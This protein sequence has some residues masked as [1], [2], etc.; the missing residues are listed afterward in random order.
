MIRNPL[1]HL[2]FILIVVIFS[3][4]NWLNNN[5]TTTVSSNPTF[6]SLTFNKSDS[7]P[8]LSTARFSLVWD[9]TLKDS[10]IM[11][12]DSLPYKTI[13]SKVIPKFSFYSTGGYIVY[14]KPALSQSSDSIILTGTDTLD[15]NRVLKIKNLAADKVKS[16]TYFIKVNVHQVRP[17]L[18]QWN[19]V[20]DNIFTHAVVKQ[21]AVFFK[22]NFLLYASSGTQNYLYTSINA[23]LWENRSSDLKGFPADCN[24]R[25]LIEFN[26]KLYV[27]SSDLKLYSSTDGF[28][29]TIENALISDSNFNFVSILYI[30]NAK[31]WSV[32]KSKTDNSYHF[33]TSTDATSWTVNGLI[34]VNFP[35]RDF[36][37]VSF[38][39]RT[40]LP[41][42]LIAGGYNTNGE[43][44]KNVW[45][46]ENGNYW[47]DFSIDNA[48]HGYIA[49]SSI[50][51]Y[52]NKLFLYGGVDKFSKVIQKP[53]LVSKDDGLSWS[54]PDTINNRLRQMNISSAND[55]TY[56]PYQ[57]RAFQSVITRD[58]NIYLI[59]GV[60]PLQSAT[61]SD[62]WIG[63]LNRL[64]FLRQ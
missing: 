31:L 32:M 5:E 23:K 40:K 55:T 9:V 3:A 26:S 21:K 38:T 1:K 44:L 25:E 27:I 17:E 59:G 37:S 39:T 46:T 54:V 12:L 34:P 60:N 49:G 11:N 45:T 22:E 2:F 19:K 20:V 8:A 36:S 64:N 42:A 14:L 15:F 33:A 57:P 13:I 41:K 24:M 10:V 62:V 7:I 48:T 18:Y 16:R 61:Y 30:Y 29:W 35:I 43:L 28:N 50:I 6:L 52:D 63:K 53:Y 47:L 58:N 51:L 56:I 4:C